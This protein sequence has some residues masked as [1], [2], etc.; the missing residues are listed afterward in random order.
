MKRTYATTNLD[1][2]APTPKRGR[3]SEV[4]VLSSDSESDALD[5]NREHDGLPEDFGIEYGSDEEEDEDEDE[6][7]DE[8]EDE[9]EDEDEEEDNDESQE[10]QRSQYHRSRSFIEQLQKDALDDFKADFLLEL[11]CL[12]SSTADPAPVEEDGAHGL[13]DVLREWVGQDKTSRRT[14]HLYYRLDHTYDENQFPPEPFLGRDV[15]VMETLDRMAGEVHLEIFLALLDREDG[16]PTP[17]YLVRSLVDRHGH[18]LI[19]DI[20]VDDNLLQA[21]VPSLGVQLP[22]SEV[23]S[24]V[25]LAPRDSVVDFLMQ[26]TSIPSTSALCFSRD[27]LLDSFANYFRARIAESS[28]RDR[29]LP[30]FKELCA[31]IW[32]LDEA[33][34]LFVLSRPILHDL[35]VEVVNLKDWDFLEEIARHLGG[36][37]LSIFTWSTDQVASGS[38]PLLKVEKR[39]SSPHSATSEN[40][41][42]EISRR[43]IGSFP[44]AFDTKGSCSYIGRFVVDMLCATEDSEGREVPK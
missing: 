41:P 29:L 16:G 11:D 33:K 1:N 13:R 14:S 36:R 19:S 35:L 23:V 21:R 31:R 27:A 42:K 15:V 18:E 4:I 37:P 40:E 24:A 3:F 44:E 22:G 6:G 5:L 7:E 17:D 20:P 28:N 38:G 10:S 43:L 9:D 2:G 32:Q 12:R 34:G 8:Y 25:M 39:H 26:Y 30:V